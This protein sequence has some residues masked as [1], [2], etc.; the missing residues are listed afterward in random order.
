MAGSKVTAPKMSPTDNSSHKRKR[1]DPTAST[2][3]S[4]STPTKKHKKEKKRDSLSAGGTEK[5]KRKLLKDSLQGDDH[6]NSPRKER[7]ASSKHTKETSADADSEDAVTKPSKKLKDGKRKSSRKDDRADDEPKTTK[8]TPKEDEDSEESS[9]NEA[10]RKPSK[11]KHAG[12]LSKFERTKTVSSKKAKKSKPEVEEIEENVVE[13]VIAKGL[14]PLPQPENPP[15]LEEAPTYSSLPPWLANPLRTST[16]ERAKFA[17]LGIKPDLLRILD[18]NNY[19]EAFAVQSTVIPLLLDG[20]NNHPGDLCISA[21]TGSGKT[22]S[23]VLP[24]VTSLNPR[25][26]SRLRGLIVVPTRELVKQAREACELCASGSRLHIGSAVGNVAIKDEQK[27]IMRTDQVYNPATVAQRQAPGLQDNDWMDF[28]LED[29]VTEAVDS[30]G[31]L[32][33]YIQRY[34]PNVD[35]L[36]CTPGRLVDHL[37]YTKGFTL[38]HLEWLVIDEADRLLNESFQEWVDVV[39]GSLDARHA[40]ETFGAG[41]KLLSQLGLPIETKPPRKVILSA[42]MTRDITK[43]NSLRLDDPKMVI[44][45]AENAMNPEDPSA[46]HSD[47]HFTLPST[48]RER[49]VAVGDESLKPLYLLRLLLSHIGVEVDRKSS[50]ASKAVDSDSTSSDDTSSDDETSSDESSDDDTSSSGSDSES[51]SDSASDTSSDAS[52]DTSSDDSSDSESESES[53]SKPKTLSKTGARPNTVLIFTKSS[54]S[55]SRLSRLISLLH[56]QLA[57]RVGTIIKSD[58]SSASRKT[59]AAYRKGKISVIVATDRASRGLDLQ[60]LSHV[61][62]YDVPSSITT[63]VHRV[64]RTARA[65]KEGSAWSLVAHREGRWFANEIA[66]SV[67]GRITRNSPIDRVQVKTNDL[68]S[69][70]EKYPKALEKLE[71]EVKGRK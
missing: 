60:S 47:A 19:K 14:E 3:V 68:K 36:I 32:P 8:S 38:K 62:N 35:I 46:T 2:S 21:A 44:I 20:D 42:T 53:E 34:E 55:A 9:D 39:M 33:G 26:A 18:Q 7:L 58:K 15:E 37:R 64:G 17:D 24:L 27:L 13:P 56:P 1:E 22:L 51:D 25:P 52:S 28:S 67:D 6:E 23:Y 49:M 40:P 59:L 71:Q 10:E 65:G 31:F 45:G 4:T 11:N 50:L 5:Q 57:S 48:L 66:A 16:D 63:Y 29:C 54:E 69:L 61:I 41:G 43:L 30:T 12:I 70:Q